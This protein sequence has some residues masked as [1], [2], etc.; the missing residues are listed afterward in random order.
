MTT[1]TPTP[2]QDRR[3]L[4][5]LLHEKAT[6]CRTET[7][8]LIGIAKSGHYTSV[9]SCAEIFAALY[10]H[11][12]RIDPARPDWPDRDRFLLGKGHAAVGL[13]P[14][15]A[16]LG[17]FPASTLEDYTRIGSAFGD[18]PDMTKI[19][20]AD[21]SSGSLGHNLSVSVGMALGGRMQ[22]RDFRVFCLLG[23][24]ELNEGQ[25]WEAAMAAGN[26][27]LGNLVAIVDQNTMSLDG[28]TREIMDI[29]PLADKFRAFKWRAVEVD[30]HDLDAL[31]ST[32]DTLPDRSDRTPTVILAHTMKGHGLS[33]MSGSR[34][35]HLGY[36]A[37]ADAAS[38]IAQIRREA[39]YPEEVDA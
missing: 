31:V 11:T 23:D 7:V 39:G 17:Y 10:Y 6:F 18:H 14:L 26:F 25:V 29:E 36:L 9:F 35:W 16:D 38:A 1:T 20:G 15:M 28:T 27:G 21:F 34:E 33:Y 19:P 12:L 30:G 37:P 22:G 3:G 24:G 32:L 8:R 2:V 13:Y 5:D 4:L